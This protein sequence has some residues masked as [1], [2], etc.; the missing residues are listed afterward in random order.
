M[1]WGYKYLHENSRIQ[2]KKQ[3]VTCC[4]Q[5]S[6]VWLRE[7][8]QPETSFLRGSERSGVCVH[9]SGSSKCCPRGQFLSWFIQNT[10]WT[11][12]VWLSGGCWNKS[13]AVGGL[14]WLAQLNVIGRH[15]TQGF[16]LGREGEER[17]MS[18]A[19]W[20]FESCPRDWYLF[21][22]TWIL[23]GDYR[24]LDPYRPLR[25]RESWEACCCKT[26]ERTVLETDN[27]YS[28]R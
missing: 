20:L 7:F 13:R 27:R 15:K 5:H 28:K 22:L 11:N 19:F 3:Q 10:E 6:L 9:R 24:I 23:S 16:C 14:L 4:G 18:L 26:G 17:S 8:A 12:I 25:I 1:I 21:H 2:F